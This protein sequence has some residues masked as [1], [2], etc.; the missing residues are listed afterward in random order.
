MNRRI[1]LRL[2]PNLRLAAKKSYRKSRGGRGDFQNI[3][4]RN[5]CPS[6]Y[7][8][9]SQRPPRLSGAVFDFFSG[10]RYV[11]ENLFGEVPV[12]VTDLH[13]SE[14]QFFDLRLDLLDLTDNYYCHLIR[15]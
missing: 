12:L 5:H 8:R 10:S 1:D 9:R 11:N 7:S 3:K 13:G 6:I 14:L 2:Q 15:L 4:R